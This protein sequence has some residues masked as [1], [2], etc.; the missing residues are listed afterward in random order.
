MSL[1]DARRVLVIIPA[2]Q[3]ERS[4]SQVVAAVRALAVDVL[5]VD[6]GSTDK[7]G[8]VALAAGASVLTLPFNMGVGGA[9]RAGY[10]YALRMGYEQAV[11]VDADGQ[12][13]PADVPLLIEALAGADV[14]IG[15]RFAEGSASYAV[16]G[17]RRY[18]MRYL[19]W[20]LTR[21]GGV[22]LTDTTSGFRAVNS[23]ALRLFATDYPVEYLGD[24]IES[25][26]LAMRS[27][28]TV[29]QVPVAMRPRQFG[30]S[31]ASPVKASLYLGRAVFVMVLARIR[32]RDE[33][34]EPW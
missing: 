25:L 11:Q 14:V 3:E 21:L 2:F 34:G 9:M 12:H 17:L 28:L 20:S 29:A 19:A 22:R 31:S 15:A 26:V 27:G 1:T 7:T 4:I 24:T 16:Q 8:A 5:V 18:A 23:R 6:D 10:K 33:I 30:K 32:R 13:N